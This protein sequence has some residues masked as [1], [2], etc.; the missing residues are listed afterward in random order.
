MIL[1]LPLPR[2]GEGMRAGTV[3][4]V[5]ARA[6]DALAPGTPVVEVH[7]E[8]DEASAR[9]CPAMFSFRLIATER[10]YLRSLR[11]AR[12][13][14]IEV[15]TSLGVAT[16]MP[17]EAFDGPATRALRTTSVSIQIDPLST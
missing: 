14:V 10:A 8:L 4:R 1:S 13:D 15:A 6:G 3:S 7:V 2:I 16:T 9:D 5:I 17:D 11:V 12:G